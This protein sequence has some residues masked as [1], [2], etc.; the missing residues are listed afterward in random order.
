MEMPGRRA[1]LQQAADLDMVVE[2]VR[3]SPARVRT[4]LAMP[5]P[6]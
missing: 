6:A 2:V 5:V 1:N 3:G 4:V